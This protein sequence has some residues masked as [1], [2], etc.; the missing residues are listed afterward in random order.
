MINEINLVDQLNNIS[1]KKSNGQHQDFWN[2]EKKQKSFYAF[3][4]LRHRNEYD[5][6]YNS[7]SLNDVKSNPSK[8]YYFIYYSSETNL[9]D[10]S[11]KLNENSKELHELIDLFKQKNVRIIFMDEAEGVHHGFI[12][13]FSN[14]LKKLKIPKKRILYINND[15][16]LPSLSENL[17]FIGKKW[18]FLFS[19]TS[20][21]YIEHSIDLEFK[22]DREFVFLTKNKIL[23]P[24]RLLILAFLKKHDLL[25]VSNYSALVKESMYRTNS[26]EKIQYLFDTN[27][28][29]E[30]QK[31][32][33]EILEEDV[34]ETK[35]EKGK[36]NIEDIESINYAGAHDLRDYESSYINI[37][38]E[39]NYNFSKSPMGDSGKFIHISEKSLKPFSM[40]QLPIIVGVPHHIKYM[41]EL[42]NFD[43]FDDFIDHSYDNEIDDVIRMRKLHSEILRV[44]SLKNKLPLYF[45]TNKNRFI[46]NREI[47]KD[48][49][50]WKHS[51]LLNFII[52]M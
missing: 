32:L 4:W 30:F 3:D 24:H 42:Y 44:S 9:S 31:Y 46:N 36:Y 21:G 13:E 51:D 11:I 40:L 38:T 6:T 34:V 52:N 14:S 1:Y 26:Y 28:L 50:K 45:K 29:N 5:I 22:K 2:N 27:I 17:N 48:I 41:R 12:E 43:M 20:N 15:A 33:P 49:S 8:K 16:L 37:T 19:N 47:I 39:S 25:K 18:H 35:Y 10:L 23:K 7:C